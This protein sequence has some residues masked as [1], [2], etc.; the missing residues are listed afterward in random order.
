MV[1][2]SPLIDAA[3]PLPQLP[4]TEHVLEILVVPRRRVACESPYETSGV[5]VVADPGAAQPLVRPLAQRV[6]F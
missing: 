6:G 1:L 2:Q 3:R 4:L 5:G